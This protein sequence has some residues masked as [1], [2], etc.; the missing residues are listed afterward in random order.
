MINSD[1]KPS[2]QNKVAASRRPVR[3]DTRPW[4]LIDIYNWSRRLL[5]KPSSVR[6]RLLFAGSPSSSLSGVR[7]AASKSEHGATDDVCRLGRISADC[8]L[9]CRRR[10]SARS[11]HSARHLAGSAR[12]RRATRTHCEACSGSPAKPW[13]PA[14]RLGE[15]AELAD[16]ALGC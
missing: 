1:S 12:R 11:A 6:K 4:L 13:E 9:G 8:S 15:P 14:S 10:S 7:L 2:G 16:V 3:H 5:A